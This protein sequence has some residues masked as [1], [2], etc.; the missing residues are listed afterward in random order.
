[1]RGFFVAS[2]ISVGAL[3]AP[4]LT[5]RAAACMTNADASQVATAFADLIRLPFNT[6]LA[7]AFMTPDFH[8][9]SDSVNE[10]INSGCPSGPAP[11]RA[12]S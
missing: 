10:L 5:E 2:L 9:Y 8:D 3:A 12:S 7:K 1:M 6:T 11:V 4:A